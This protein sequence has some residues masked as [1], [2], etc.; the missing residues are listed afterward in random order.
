M[1]NVVSGEAQYTP[2]HKRCDDLCQ[3]YIGVASH[4]AIYSIGNGISSRDDIIT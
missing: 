1:C 2:L 4:G 3:L